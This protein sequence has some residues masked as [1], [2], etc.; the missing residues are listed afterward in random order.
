L[1]ISHLSWLEAC[2]KVETTV[3]KIV[4]IDNGTVIYKTKYCDSDFVANETLIEK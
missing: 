1:K 2:K 3:A 4:K